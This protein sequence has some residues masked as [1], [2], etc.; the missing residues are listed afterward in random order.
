MMRLQKPCDRRGGGFDKAVV[1]NV[2][3]GDPAMIY[4]I[5]QSEAQNN[6]LV[7]N[8]SNGAVVPTAVP[9]I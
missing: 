5:I 4:E 2:A 3:P 7:G 1:F 6:P 9:D 8:V